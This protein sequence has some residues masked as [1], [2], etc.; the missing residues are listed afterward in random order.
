MDRRAPK[1]TQ[2]N[3]NIQ[4]LNPWP[5]LVPPLDQQR[6]IVSILNA[7]D[8]KIDLH[9]RRK[10]IFEELFRSLLRK[11]MTGE[12]RIGDLD[13]STLERGIVDTA[14]TA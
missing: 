3:I 8:K 9:Q 1:G 2:K 10:V 13:F 14:T 11:L 6:E 4:F 5:I 7:I 12:I